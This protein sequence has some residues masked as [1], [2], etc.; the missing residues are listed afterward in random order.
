MKK[1]RVSHREYPISHNLLTRALLSGLLPY[2]PASHFNPC[3]RIQNRATFLMTFGENYLIPE[4]QAAEILARISC[5]LILC[6]FSQQPSQKDCGLQYCIQ[7]AQR[8][9]MLCQ[10]PTSKCA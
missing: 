6:P 7:D 9:E 5:L 3:P 10:D 1:L 4:V 2:K 8:I